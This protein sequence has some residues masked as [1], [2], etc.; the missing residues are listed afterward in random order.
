MF[1]QVSEWNLSD[2]NKKGIQ[3][4]LILICCVIAIVWLFIGCS[5]ND[6]Q[7]T[8]DNYGQKEQVCEGNNLYAVIVGQKKQ[9]ISEGGCKDG[10]IIMSEEF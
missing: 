7:H 3:Y 1:K 10:K 6:Y 9:L 8:I 4:Y 5:K 2:N